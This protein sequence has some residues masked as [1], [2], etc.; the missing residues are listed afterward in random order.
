MEKCTV[1]ASPAEQFFLE[2]LDPLYF[3]VFSAVGTLRQVI[4]WGALDDGEFLVVEGSAGGGV[5][6]SLTPR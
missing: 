6:G 1:D 5:A 4:F 2:N 3:E